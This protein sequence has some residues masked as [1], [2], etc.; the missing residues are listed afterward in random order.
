MQ[1]TNVCTELD[2]SLAGLYRGILDFAGALDSPVISFCRRNSGVSSASGVTVNRVACGLNPPG[3]PCLFVGDSASQAADRIAGD[4]DLLVVHSLFRGHVDWAKRYADRRRATLW[5]IPHGCFDPWGLR[6]R[7]V[8][9][10]A[11]LALFGAP[12]F[13]RASVTLFATHR[14]QEKAQPWI[15]STRTAVIPWP[16]PLPDISDR[17]AA[18][19]RFRQRL[20]IPESAIILLY[21]ARLHRMKRPLETVAAFCASHTRNAHLVMIG[22]DGDIP[23]KQLAAAVPP[24]YRSH[25]HI[26]GPLYGSDLHDAWL[27]ADGFISL[28]YRENFGYSFAE[29]LGYD[30][31]VIVSPGHDLAWDLP[32]DRSGRWPYGWLLRDDSQRSATEA[33]TDFLRCQSP[34]EGVGHTSKGQPSNARSWVA[35]NLAPGRFREHLH[36]L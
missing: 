22:M 35:E 34:G 3:Y 26:P 14:E 10:R 21:A 19:S 24:P 20:S 4:A 15:G 8:L 18:R 16:V 13:Q 32:M 5:S 7:W 6:H 27:A 17:P 28:S 9:K 30:L 23:G 11:W 36:R 12:F 29:A 2:P 33:I 31:P 25:I 1:A